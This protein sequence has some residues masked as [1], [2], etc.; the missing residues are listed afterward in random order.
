MT[1]TMTKVKPLAI[2][3]DLEKLFVYFPFLIQ[4]KDETKI[5]M[6]AWEKIDNSEYQYLYKVFSSRKLKVKLDDVGFIFNYLKFIYKVSKSSFNTENELLDNGLKELWPFF[7]MI[8]QQ[9]KLKRIS[10]QTEDL[11]TVKI[12]SEYALKLFFKIFEH[13]IKYLSG[14]SYTKKYLLEIQQ[15]GYLNS[16]LK[17]RPGNKI[18]YTETV[19]KQAVTM[20]KNYLIAETV[21]DGKKRISNHTIIGE[22][23]AH[24]GFIEV[25]DDDMKEYLTAAEYYN[26]MASYRD[27]EKGLKKT[28]KIKDELFPPH[29]LI[30]L[31]DNLI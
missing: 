8:E 14:M 3:P 26:K 4:V 20:F 18:D 10:I 2:N 6:T 30:Q 28:S 21:T 27:L 11:K 1:N 16:I 24:I 15:N 25:Y 29:F 23:L 7:Q 9:K 17:R 13:S 22:I 31:N 5:K 12:T 19:L